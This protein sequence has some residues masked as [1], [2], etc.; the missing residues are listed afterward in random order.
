[1]L[2]EMQAVFR[3]LI[4][5]LELQFH[6][7]F[8]SSLDVVSLAPVLESSAIRYH[9]TTFH[10]AFG[11]ETEYQGPPTPELELRWGSLWMRGMIEVSQ[12]VVEKLNK[13]TEN[14]KPVVSDASNRGYAAVLEVFHHLHCLNQIR[15]FTW[16]DYYAI[17]MSEWVQEHPLIIDLNVTNPQNDM[18]R[19]HVDHC[20]EALR[21]QLMCAA[22]VTPV[23]LQ[24]DPDLGVKA[25]FDV[26]HRCRDWDMITNWQYNNK[27]ELK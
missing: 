22:D 5:G 9:D 11:M 10:N 27:V 18:D 20:I 19:K 15:Q 16:K 6:L 13:S 24:P 3:P 23:L 7:L 21:L 17:H 4:E 8:D 1:M 14:L 26:Y 12:N 2:W 25:D